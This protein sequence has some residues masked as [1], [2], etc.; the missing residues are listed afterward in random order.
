[1]GKKCA[2][3]SFENLDGVA[4]ASMLVRWAKLNKYSYHL[5]FM[6]YSN[7]DE[8]FNMWKANFESLAVLGIALE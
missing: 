2:I 1:M 6:N 4:A 3:Y 5:S 8:V 7:V